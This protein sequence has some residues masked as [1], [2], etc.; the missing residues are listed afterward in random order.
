METNVLRKLLL[1]LL[2]R[3]NICVLYHL[4]LFIFVAISSITMGTCFGV[5]G[6]ILGGI[7]VFL[8][9][10]LLKRNRN[11]PVEEVPNKKRVGRDINGCNGSERRGKIQ[12]GN[13]IDTDNKMSRK[14]ACETQ[15]LWYTYVPETGPVAH[16]L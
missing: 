3:V 11:Q 5:F 8:Y 9:K 7:G 16:I 12:E 4:T 1:C 6:A 15:T 2:Q 13:V 10:R 14:T